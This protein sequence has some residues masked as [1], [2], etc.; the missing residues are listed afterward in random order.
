[1][2]SNPIEDPKSALEGSLVKGADRA[3]EQTRL[4]NCSPGRTARQKSDPHY[5]GQANLGLAQALLRHTQA[6]LGFARPQLR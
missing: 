6:L 3:P 1:M 2:C 4:G 5:G